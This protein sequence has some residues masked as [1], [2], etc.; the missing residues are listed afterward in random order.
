MDKLNLKVWKLSVLV[1]IIYTLFII[2][3][4]LGT[5]VGITILNIREQVGID[6]LL[7]YL[8]L[9]FIISIVFIVLYIL[10]TLNI[11]KRTKYSDLSII[12]SF[13]IY[14][15]MVMLVYLNVFLTIATILDYISSIIVIILLTQS[16]IKTKN[17]K[18]L[19][20]IGI[21]LVISQIIEAF[22]GY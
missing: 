2:F 6:Y 20:S 8:N 1:Y 9:F 19:V 10:L 17:Y 15:L 22:L 12:I 7:S 11:V 5:N 4:A 14:I 18:T 13:P 3:L 16:L 21:I